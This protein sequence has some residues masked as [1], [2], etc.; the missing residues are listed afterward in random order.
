M[1]CVMKARELLEELRTIP[2]TNEALGP[3]TF[4]VTHSEVSGMASY[5]QNVLNTIADRMHEVVDN[6]AARALTVIIFQCGL[7]TARELVR[8]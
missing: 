3:L 8:T 1:R 5:R 7:E 2:F 6:D 4:R